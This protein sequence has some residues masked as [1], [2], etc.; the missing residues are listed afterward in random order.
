MKIQV[1]YGNKNYV[2]ELDA[3]KVMDNKSLVLKELMGFESYKAPVL[4]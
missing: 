2:F 3:I 4:K 1:K